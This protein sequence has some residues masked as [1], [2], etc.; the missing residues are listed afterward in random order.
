M[1]TL[2]EDIGEF[3]GSGQIQYDEASTRAGTLSRVFMMSFVF[4]LVKI[5]Y[6]HFYDGS[7]FVLE[8]AK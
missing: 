6:S 4:N 1:T 2:Q 5:A 7:R 3:D 8:N